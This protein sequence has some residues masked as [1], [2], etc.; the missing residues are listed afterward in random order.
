MDGYVV[1]IARDLALRLRLEG[2][3]V[4][5]NKQQLGIARG[6]DEVVK[7]IVKPPRAAALAEGGIEALKAMVSVLKLV[8]VPRECS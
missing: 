8:V 5:K 7:G 4:G 6:A 2:R 1:V 3:A